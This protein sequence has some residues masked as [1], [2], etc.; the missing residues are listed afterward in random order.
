M[1]SDVQRGRIFV[2]FRVTGT[3]LDPWLITHI[4]G[5]APTR[6]FKRGDA[7]DTYGNLTH[8]FGSWSVTAVR[9]AT[10]TQVPNVESMILEVLE[11]LG[12]SGESFQAM[13]GVE[14]VGLSIAMY[15]EENY[16][17]VFVITHEVMA[18]IVK[19]GCDLDVDIYCLEE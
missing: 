10:D 3:E 9:Q 4:T 13:D 2:S 1:R 16:S 12:E 11:Y 18:K 14:Y 6:A 8:T 5:L 15:I 19:L 7:N 17:P